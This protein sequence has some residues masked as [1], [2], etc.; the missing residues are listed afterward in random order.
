MLKKRTKSRP[1]CT[2]D[3][4]WELRT[5]GILPSKSVP[6][7]LKTAIISPPALFPGLSSDKDSDGKGAVRLLTKIQKPTDPGA[8][9]GFAAAKNADIK[10]TTN[11]AC[12]VLRFNV[13]NAG[14]Q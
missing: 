5:S 10:E 8:P 9:A 13:R 7:I 12:P 2:Q 6:M 3:W 11:A 14:G 4:A 1:V